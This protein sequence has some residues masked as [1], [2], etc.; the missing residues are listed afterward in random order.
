MTTDIFT[1]LRAGEIATWQEQEVGS[2]RLVRFEVRES[3]WS[4]VIGR[5]VIKVRLERVKPP[6]YDCLSPA[7]YI[8]SSSFLISDGVEGYQRA[9]VLAMVEAYGTRTAVEA[10]R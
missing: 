6:R 7:G 8:G 10:T 1:A 3:K 2:E 9:R 5:A 4:H